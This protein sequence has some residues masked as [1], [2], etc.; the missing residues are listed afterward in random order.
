MVSISSLLDLK[1]VFFL[2]A[3]AA[4]QGLESAPALTQRGEHPTMS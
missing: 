2:F 3:H 4:S 1:A